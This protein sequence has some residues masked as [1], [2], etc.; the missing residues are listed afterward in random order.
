[1]VTVAG[2]TMADPGVISDTIGSRDTFRVSGC[3]GAL[4]KCAAGRV[5]PIN[6]VP[7]CCWAC[8]ESGYWVQPLPHRSHWPPTGRVLACL[9]GSRWRRLDLVAAI[10]DGDPSSGMVRGITPRLAAPTTTLR[11]PSGVACAPTCDR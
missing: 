1:M 6:R 7:S 5:Q 2:A 11:S 10:L 9:R 3:V 8:L 4:R